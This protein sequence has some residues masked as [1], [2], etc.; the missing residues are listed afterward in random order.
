MSLK[1]TKFTVTL[2]VSLFCVVS[3]FSASSY[4]W[5]T[6]DNGHVELLDNVVVNNCNPSDSGP[7]GSVISSVATI[8]Q[9][10]DAHCDACLD[11]AVLQDNATF[12]KRLKRP[13][14][15]TAV[16]L[17]PEAVFSDYYTS[18][19]TVAADLLPQP[20]PSF[21]R[22]ILEHKTIVLLI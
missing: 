17:F 7:G 10:N 19:K 22:A 15:S 20:S 6:G 13:I 8:F 5:C 14:A 11:F 3:V 16:F 12:V 1:F 2:F 9:A 4:A 18:V 21:P